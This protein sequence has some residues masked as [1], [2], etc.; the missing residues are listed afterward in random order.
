VI[1]S[2]TEH[3]QLL[4]GAVFIAVVLFLPGGLIS[5]GRLGWLRR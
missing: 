1:S 2:Y 5:L 4:L 3:W